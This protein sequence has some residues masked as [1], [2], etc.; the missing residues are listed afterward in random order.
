V[1]PDDLRMMEDFIERTLRQ[2]RS[3]QDALADM[4]TRYNRIPSGT[5]RNMSERMIAVLKNEIA[6][7]Q[8]GCAPLVRTVLP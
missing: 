8:K 5:E 4:V 2:R 7:R 6:V 1:S 3:L